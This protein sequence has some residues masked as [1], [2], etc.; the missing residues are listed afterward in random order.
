MIARRSL[1]YLLVLAFLAVGEMAAIAAIPRRPP[2][3][4]PR[5]S[6]TSRSRTDPR[7]LPAKRGWDGTAMSISGSVSR[8]IGAAHQ[9][10]ADRRAG[11]HERQDGLVP[12]RDQRPLTA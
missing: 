11:K 6:A 7:L 4:Q 10:C 5:R 9:S 2:M 12:A 8:S 1:A 3:Q